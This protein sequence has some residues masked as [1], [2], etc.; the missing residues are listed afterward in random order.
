MAERLWDAERVKPVPFSSIR[1]VMQEAER[2]AAQGRKVFHMEIGRPDFDTPPHIK[3]AAIKA[4]NEGMVHYGA[5]LGLPQLTA[6]IADKLRRENGVSVDPSGGVLVGAGVKYIVYCVMQALVN[7]GEEVLLPDPCWLD[8]FACV[9][10][11]GGVPVAVP[12]REENGFQLDPDE[13]ER[14]ITP[15]TRILVVITPHNPT[16]TVASKEVL[17]QLT[18]VAQ[19]RDILVLSDEIYEKIIY[20]GAVHH[21]LAS[22]PGMAER[23]ITVNGFS[24]AYAMDGWRLGYAAASKALIQPILKVHMS[25]MSCPNTFIQMGAVAAYQGPQDSVGRMVAEFD[26]RRKMMLSAMADMPGVKVARPEGSF[27]LFPNLKAFGMTSMEMAAYLMREAGIASVPGS[28]F[29]EWGEG[30][31]RLAYSDTYENLAAGMASLKDALA[32]LPRQ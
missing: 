23:T 11:A 2:L 29:G 7:P 5:S 31:V 21:S 24:K 10:L 15:K 1:V 28:A 14:L 13:V 6:A 20:D 32:K 19:R 26:R 22:F 8:Y 16:G 12:L 25:A 9:R 3:Q 18:E 30:H 17:R 4:L 27:Y